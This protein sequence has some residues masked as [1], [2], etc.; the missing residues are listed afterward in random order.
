[1]LTAKKAAR[2][3]GVLPSITKLMADDRQLK[4]TIH[5][6]VAGEYQTITRCHAQVPPEMGSV[7]EN[8]LKLSRDE[9]TQGANSLGFHH[10]AA[11]SAITHTSYMDPQQMHALPHL[12]PSICVEEHVRRLEV[13]VDDDLAM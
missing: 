13:A 11:L 7:G 8:S 12:G 10:S 4:N 5:G 3:Y 9:A 6:N 1:M 2:Y